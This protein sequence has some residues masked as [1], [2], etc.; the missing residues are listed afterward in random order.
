MRIKALFPAIALLFL[1]NLVPTAK[2]DDTCRVTEQTTVATTSEADGS[3]RSQS[4]SLFLLGTGL[5]LAGWSLKRLRREL[6]IPICVR[7]QHS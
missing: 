4:A 7:H 6:P 1:C 3:T 2:A 5:T